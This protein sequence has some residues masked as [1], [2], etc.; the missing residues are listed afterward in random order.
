[1]GPAQLQLPWKRSGG[2]RENEGRVP[3]TEIAKRL[4]AIL[5]QIMPFLSQEHQQQVAQAVER[6]KQV[7]MTELNAIIGWL[8]S[9]NEQGGFSLMN[10]SFFNFP[11]VSRFHSRLAI[12]PF[13]LP[14]HSFFKNMQPPPTLSVL[15]KHTHLTHSYHISSQIHTLRH[16]S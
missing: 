3:V 15:Y 13:P 5:A 16:S 7:T 9:W 2:Q 4:N 11:C 14:F 8:I 10:H 1:M 12:A 6:A